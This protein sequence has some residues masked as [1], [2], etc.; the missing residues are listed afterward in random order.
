MSV[1]VLLFTGI[2]MAQTPG[3]SATG[4]STT[5]NFTFPS[6]PDVNDILEVNIG[7]SMATNHDVIY[8]T[9]TQGSTNY[10]LNPA[11]FENSLAGKTSFANNTT[12]YWWILD[13]TG[14][15]IIDGAEGG[16]TAYSFKTILGP[17]ATTGA[18][19]TTSTSFTVNWTAPT[20]GGA[21]TYIL[22][23][24]T[25][26]GG[27]DVFSGN[28]GSG[29]SY[30]IANGGT[31]VLQTLTPNTTY[32]YS[33]IAVDASSH[34]S[35]A[36]TPGSVTTLIAP[37]T[38]TT[39]SGLTSAGFTA[40]WTANTY[41][42]A[43]TY[44]LIVGTS[45]GASD[46]FSG[47]VG[48]GLS[49]AI[50]NGGTGVL[51]AITS[52]TP[53]YYEVEAV[54]SGGAYTTG[55]S[56][57][58]EV[59]T[60]L[61]AA[62]ALPAT[63]PT[64]SGFTANWSTYTGAASYTLNITNVT[65]GT[66][67]TAI[68]GL[69]GTSYAVTGLNPNTNYSYTV[70][71]VVTGT[72]TSSASNSETVTTL[73]GAP[74][75]AGA[76]LVSTTSFTANWTANT[77]GGASSYTLIV[78]G[79]PTIAGITGLSQPVTGLA[80]NTAY[81]YTVEA[82]ETSPAYTTPASASNA[83]TT[84]A[85]LPAGSAASSVAINSF[86]ANWNAVAGASS[87]I[88]NVVT[89]PGGVT[90]FS[91]NVGNVVTYSVGS[92]SS[93]T[94][95]AYTVEAVLGSN[96]TIAS[97]PVTVTTL[98]GPP[99]TNPA[100]GITS[101]GFTAS[102]SSYASATSYILLIGTTSGGSDVFN[103]NVGNV[104]TYP[105]TTLAPNT[106]YYYSVEAVVGGVVGSPS[107]SQSFTTLIAAPV[108]IQ[109]TLVTATSFSANWNASLN[110]GAASYILNV[111]TTSGGSNTFSGNVGNVLTYSVT[112]LS[113]GTL[114]YY[115]VV[116]VPASGGANTG[117]SNV[118]TVTAN[119]QSLPQ[120]T[121][122][123]TGVSVLP[124]FTWASVP[125]ASSYVLHVSNNSGLATG[126]TNW[127]FSINVGLVTTYNTYYELIANSLYSNGFPLAQGTLYYWKVDPVVGGTEETSSVNH[128]TTSQSFA[129]TL[130][131][132]TNGSS[133]SSSPADFSWWLN[134]ST[135]GLQFIVQYA[136]AS[137]PPV[138]ESFWQTATTASFSQLGVSSPI[139]S[140]SVNGP[141]YSGQTYYWRVLVQ[142]TAA[143]NDFIYYPQGNVYNS[144]TTPGG[145][146]VS[147]Y[148]SWPTNGNTDYQNPPTLSWYL[149][150][151]ATGLTYQV[152]YSSTSGATNPVTGELS[153][154]SAILIPAGQTPTTTGIV[155]LSQAL[156][157]L[158]AGTYYWQVRAIYY[159]GSSY[160]YSAWSSPTSFVSLGGG[161]GTP[162]VP[163]A[164]YPTGGVIVYSTG[165]QLSWYL[166]TA[167]SG[168]Y[169]DIQ[170]STDPNM[171]TGVSSYETS[172]Q[173]V[174]SYNVTGLTAGQTYYWRVRSDLSSTGLGPWSSWSESTPVAN[175]TFT[176][177]SSGT[178]YAVA[179]WP[180]GNPTVYTS[181]PTLSWYLNGDNTNVTGYVVKY[182]MIPLASVPAD[183]S[184]YTPTTSGGTITV[185]GNSTFSTTIGTNLIPGDTYYWGV[186]SVG[187][188]TSYNVLGQGSFTI[189]NSGQSVVLTNPGNGATV[190]GTS[191]PL[192]WY[193]EGSPVGLTGYTV[194]Y[195]QSDTYS[196]LI[197]TIQ[198]A[199]GTQTT[200]ISG[201]TDGATYYW[202][203]TAAFTGEAPIQSQ[204]YSFTVNTGSLSIVEPLIGG[205]TNV[206]IT[207]SAPELSWVLKAPTVA[208]TTYELELASNSN[209][210]NAKTYTSSKPFVQVT[211]LSGGDNYY[212]KV[213][214]KDNDGNASY[215]SNT[216]R[217][218]VKTVTAVDNKSNLIPK[219]FAV[220]QN[221]PNPFNPSTV[222]NYALPK[223]SLVTIK[224][225]NILG[226][227]VKTLI[228]SQRQAGYYTV[229]WNGDNNFGRTVASGIYIY[230]VEAGQYVKTMKMMLLK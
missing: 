215:Y 105:V 118:I 6:T 70:Q 168:L 104:T 153:D 47:N 102:W 194:Q 81:S 138:D 186:Y 7:A 162:V 137:A 82:V 180:I 135:Y 103:Q 77:F 99:T 158:T 142:R 30:A 24:G 42:G 226:Q 73:I 164:S 65:L 204:W 20:N 72:G 171:V 193:I 48:S 93:N 210:S 97:A 165:Q 122:G 50:N 208:G 12:Y 173:D 192:S 205:P 145:S 95:Y 33:V 14:V 139:T 154:P 112:G 126:G 106:T 209:F 113:S 170:I 128:F 13:P 53:Y 18:T 76:T 4:V 146:S 185:T 133:V 111:G 60:L 116:A 8:V 107:T 71:A 130:S 229:Q 127:T 58:M 147:V 190:Y 110:G 134:N 61:G 224:I 144:F 183:W 3:E 218:S 220:S 29:L 66:S 88:L 19:P 151:S 62:T 74:T 120:P 37:P 198:V 188:G 87:Y 227:E 119:S 179:T 41:G 131:T 9:L 109:A 96:T 230:R 213:R 221:Y 207:T 199:P 85:T 23:V 181:E 45:S 174:T 52:N 101:T 79:G 203:V 98:V 46:V 163:I 25:T 217:F 39:A 176:I 51:E 78:A 160:S 189:V 36:S 31:G 156:P 35:V 132:P 59:T 115:S 219:E 187:T 43:A 49:Y 129:V 182:D 136:Y 197:G 117:A 172:S 63:S 195:S 1:L 80:A 90:V 175:A 2:S 216:G 84:L 5:T 148:P 94:G 155:G 26:S 17:P 121:N 64:S 159:N 143:P 92:L 108:A 11:V 15:T 34:N 202:Q 150:E 140:N 125:T 57:I 178:G 55:P 10:T 166:N 68:T 21:S 169:Y 228:N 54:T 152:A 212:W 161:T 44:Y 177:A 40:T 69:T 86:T 191:V 100:S 56:N 167:A 16:T 149:S 157:S 201:L 22:N 200:T 32:Y 67:L 89:S 124:T 225:Y 206:Q 28:I 222:I 75:V 211:G 214:S 223:S 83:V 184:A 38:A 27:S 141:V 123:I 91:G 196:P 114:Y